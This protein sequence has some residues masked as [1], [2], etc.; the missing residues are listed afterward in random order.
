M[1]L[2]PFSDAGNRAF[3]RIRGWMGPMK[4]ANIAEQEHA[5]T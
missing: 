3:V 1:A 5:N 2:Q 4:D